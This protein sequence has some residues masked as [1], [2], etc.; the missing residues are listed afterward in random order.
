M[1]DSGDMVAGV[2]TPS[3]LQ[4]V[5]YLHDNFPSNFPGLIKVISVKLMK[6]RWGRNK[7]A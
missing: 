6:L 2:S 7:L 3:F 1:D 5:L 4:D